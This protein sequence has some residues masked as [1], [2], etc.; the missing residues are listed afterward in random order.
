MDPSTRGCNRLAS[1]TLDEIC[2]AHAADDSLQPAVQLLKDQAKPPHSS[3]CQ[4]PEDTC[5]CPNGTHCSFKRI[6][7]IVSSIIRMGLQIFCRSSYWLSCADRTS[8]GCMLTLAILG[9]PRLATQ[10]PAMSTFQG[11]NF[12]RLLVCNCAVCN[13]HQWSHQTPRRGTL[14][15]MWQFRPMAVLHAD[16][17]EPLLEGPNSRK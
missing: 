10:C 16:F 12:T 3:L 1:I 15:P 14:K 7:F 6:S 2:Q 17:V 9:G 5:C 11:G 4:Y 8:N 13:L